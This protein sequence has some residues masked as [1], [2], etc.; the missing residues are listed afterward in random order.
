MDDNALAEPVLIGFDPDHASEAP[1]EF[2][3]ALAAAI[4]A[5]PI[6]IAIRQ[7]PAYQS[8]LEEVRAEL[9]AQL[10]D[11]FDA[12]EERHSDVGLTT[13]TIAGPAAASVLYDEAERLHARAIVVGSC[14]R[15]AF[16]RTLAGSTAEA[17]LNGA[18]C[19]VVIAPRADP[20]HPARATKPALTR[21]ALAYDNSAESKSALGTA[22]ALAQRTSASLTLL[23]VADYPSY[24]YGTL[25]PALAPGTIDERERRERDRLVGEAL[26]EIPSGL[27]SEA[28][29]LN[30]DAAT[31]LADA[32]AKFDLMIT[33]S[34]S[35]GPLRRVLLGSVTRR[36]ARSAGCPILVV[37]RGA[38][39]DPLGVGAAKAPALAEA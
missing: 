26:V 34:R 1:V 13:R 23:A 8:R 3:V 38:G 11:Q 16:G 15:G 10:Q 22:V 6:I 2:G 19:P 7:W 35:Y 14:H 39:T 33:G 28:T 37:P 9:Q 21:I 24:V 31:C 29:V 27:E 20:G 36:L 17:L 4:G 32:S 5:H 25:W 30:G 12:L 18:P